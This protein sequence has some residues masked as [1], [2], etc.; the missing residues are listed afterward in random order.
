MCR[1][2]EL[3][4]GF[5]WLNSLV[6]GI[7]R[8]GSDQGKAIAVAGE[9][10]ECVREDF[11]MEMFPVI[12]AMDADMQGSLGFEVGLRRFARQASLRHFPEVDLLIG[13][14]CRLGGDGSAIRLRGHGIDF[15]F[16]GMERRDRLL[17]LQSQSA[18]QQGGQHRKSSHGTP[19]PID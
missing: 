19:R 6:H 17:G 12:F 11:G 1:R 9:C 7:G 3:H 18:E 10:F 16:S 4:R 2:L 15:P 5:F 13:A 8:G 14:E